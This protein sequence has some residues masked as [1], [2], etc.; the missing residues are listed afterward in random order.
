MVKIRVVA[1]T[2]EKKQ[3]LALGT[4][5]ES[6]HRTTYLWIKSFVEKNGKMPSEAE[7]FRA[8]A[9][10]HLKEHPNYYTKLKEAGL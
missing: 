9:S 1:L 6:E 7:V 4:Q 5:I 10:D 2:E 3:E 8:I